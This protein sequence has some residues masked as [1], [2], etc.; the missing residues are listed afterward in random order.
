MKQLGETKPQLKSTVVAVFIASEENSSI[1][2]VG[3]DALVKDGVLEKLKQGPYSSGVL[4]TMVFANT[5]EV[6][7]AV[8]KI[9]T[10]AGLEYF[11]YHNDSSLKERTKNLLDFQQEDGVFVCTDDAT[12]GID[13][14]N[15]SHVIQIVLFI[16][17]PNMNRPIPLVTK[18]QL[19]IV[20]LAK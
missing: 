6:V 17:T 1:P 7:E 18:E 16:I 12:H 4:R 11:Y 9:L 10:G 3:V 2:R 5:V 14:P 8:A 15:V 13:I 20:I 19:E